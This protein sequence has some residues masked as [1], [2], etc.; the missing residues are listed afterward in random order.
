[1]SLIKILEYHFGEFQLK[2]GSRTLEREGVRVPLGSKAFELLAYLAR[3]SGQV[4]TKEELLKAVWQGSYVEEK[5]L[6]QQILSLRKA[7]SDRAD[8]IATVSG[9]GY[10]FTAL[11]REVPAVNPVPEDVAQDVVHSIHKRTHFVIEESIRPA[12]STRPRRA[13]RYAAVAV[14]LIAG[15]IAA[16]RFWPRG[17]APEAYLGTVVAD[18]TNTTGDAAF[19]LSVKRAIEI[20]LGQSPFVGVLSDQDTVNTLGL[21]GMKPDTPLSPAIAR[22]VCER[23]NQQVLLT[24]GI[25]S[26]G[27]QYLLTMEA[28]NCLTGKLVAAAKAEAESKDKLLGAVDALAGGMRAKLGESAKSVERYDVPLSQAATSSLEALRAYSTGQYIDSQGVSGE[29]QLPLY[30]KAVELDPQFTLAYL[31]MA[32][33][34]YEL[35]EGRE[36][37]IYYKKAFDLRDRVGQDERLGIEARYYALGQG[38]A[39]KGLTAYQAWA[40]MYPHDWRP[41]LNIANLDNQLGNYPQA[42]DAGKQAVQLNPNARDYAVAVRAYKNASRFAEAKALMNEAERRGLRRGGNSNF[43]IAFYEH[44]KATFDREVKDEED[45]QWQLRNYYLGQA[46]SMEGKYAETKQL[47]QAEMDEDRRLNKGEI[48]DGVLVEL[49]LIAREY[50]YPAEARAALARISKGYLDG[51][52]V[53]YEFAMN[54]DITFARRY[55]A[56]H[57]HDPH[58][59]TDQAVIV[60]PRLRSAVAMQEGRLAEA[61]A[62]LEPARPYELAS[63]VT[64]TNRAA[65]YM[66]MGEPGKAVEDYKKI[67]ANPGAGFGVLYPMAR[68]GLA[69]AEAAAGDLAA[70]REAYQGFLSD[71]KN[72]DA[73]LPVL[74][75]A[76]AELAKIEH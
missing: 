46:R 3:H 45:S 28:T 39:V 17:V 41:W 32:R 65:I 15:G 2:L 74:K 11:V 9:R 49:A 63:F 42:I 60:M 27:H 62:A 69:R 20:E 4:V 55:V 53:A 44:D 43:E 30:Q 26:V 76:K 10:Q 50:G 52:D 5:N 64:L 71:W 72:A 36:A 37:A 13:W 21:M 68:L 57:E 14:A 59:P 24:G 70:S 38:D 66:K 33:S 67:L 25:A 56:V 48:A 23:T 58:A 34:Y 1:M 47:M 31:A 35:Q 22:E 12:V 54:G 29:N 16:Q 6:A 19:D 7:L 8:Y 75:A 40:A 18:F 51:N 73:D 61:L